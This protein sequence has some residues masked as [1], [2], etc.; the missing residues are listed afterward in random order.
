MKL[1]HVLKEAGFSNSD[2]N[3]RGPGWQEEPDYEEPQYETE[4]TQV[5][6]STQD[7]TDIQVK[8]EY[9]TTG[10]DKNP[11]IDSVEVVAVVLPSGKEVE[12]EVAMQMLGDD[13][14]LNME[15]VVTALNEQLGSQYRLS[16]NL[17]KEMEQEKGQAAAPATPAA[18]P[19]VASKAPTVA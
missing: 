19:A 5:T 17:R 16:R 9:T 11:E 13:Q 10:D 8:V 4:T 6:V 3:Y 7:G 15:Y 18:A 1:K 12:P 14:F 2:P